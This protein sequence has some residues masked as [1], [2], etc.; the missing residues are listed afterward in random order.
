MSFKPTVVTSSDIARL[1]GVSRQAVSSVLTG[2]GSSKVSA[3][4]HSRILRLASELGYRSNLSA[5]SLAGHRTN[6]IALLSNWHGLAGAINRLIDV[7]LRELGYSPLQVGI[8]TVVDE[9]LVSDLISRGAEGIICLHGLACE[10][11][12]SA[13][14][15]LQLGY[16]GCDVDI[17]YDASSHLVADHLLYH[18]HRKVLIVNALEEET[19]G[20]W[21]FASLMERMRSEGEVRSICLLRNPEG[22][23]QI[24]EAVEQGFT[25]IFCA[26]DHIAWRLMTFLRQHGYR[27]PEDVALIAFGGHVYNEYMNPSL[28]S[29]V[30][31]VTE[32][33]ELTVKHMLE[34]IDTDNR[35]RLKKTVLVKPK[36]NLGR[37][38]GCPERPLKCVFW[39]GNFISVE[40]AYQYIEKAPDELQ[41]QYSVLPESE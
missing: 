18:Q 28:T 11:E 3:A 12:R 5:L 36:L 8:E 22:N 1:V 27:I 20:R 17:D 34:K 38:C 37:S 4:K 35:K 33:A 9:P 23:R 39:E 7:R 15:I 31:P 19:N 29:V 14:P 26:Y 32:L 21:K 6:T 40:S 24:L 2:R 25:G 30:Y 41:D 13:V 16:D 10:R